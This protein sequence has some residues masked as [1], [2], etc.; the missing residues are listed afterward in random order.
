MTRTTH[1]RCRYNTIK[2]IDELI[3]N[4]EFSQRSEALDKVTDTYVRAKKLENV[5][6]LGMKNIFVQPRAPRKRYGKKGSVQDL[7]Y[8]VVVMF[9][10]ALVGLIGYT[11]SSKFMDKVTT[12]DSMPTEA[13]TMGNQING[14]YTSVYDKALPIILIGMCVVAIVLA[15]LVRVHPAFIVFF[16]IAWVF[17]IIIAGVMSN[18]YVDIAA[19]TQLAG[20]ATNLTMTMFVLKWLP[21]IVGVMGAVLMFILYKQ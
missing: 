5:M 6:T 18:A 20:Y 17:V 3:K 12:T 9:V 1:V 13:V 16:I 8:I 2:R 11:I 4:G 19:N 10:V 15:T 14:Y 7:M 21:W